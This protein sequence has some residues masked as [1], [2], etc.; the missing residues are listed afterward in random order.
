MRN[1]GIGAA[2]AVL[3]TFLFVKQQ[4]ADPEKHDRFVHDLQ[5]LKQLDAEINRDLLNSRY[6]LLSSYD[7]FVRKLD[8]MR[9]VGSNLHSIPSFIGGQQRDQIE[10]LVKRQDELVDEKTRLV[11]IFKSKNAILKNSL[12]YFPVLIEEASHAAA[13]AKDR[14]L[15]DHLASLLR[16]ILL[17]DL[18]PHSD[19]AAS[20]EPE[21]DLLLKNAARRA[22]S[23]A[24]LSSAAAH[25]STIAS[26]KS[27]VEAVTEALNSLP[28]ARSIDAISSA[29]IRDYE[30]AHKVQQIYRF[31]LYLCSVT[32]LGYGLDRT[33][34]LLKSQVE[35]EQARAANEAKSQFLANMSHEIRT[36][37]N[38]IIGMTELALDTE[39]T[40]EQRECLGMVKSSADSL[41]LLI[42]DI[43][44]FSKIEAGKLTLETIEFS[45]RDIL[46]SAVKAVSVRA[47][48][49]S[50]ELMY[51]IVPDV[52]DNLRGDP[53]RLRQIVLNLI[54][55]AVKFTSRGEV[56]LRVE[57]EEATE[58]AVTLHFIVSDTGVGIPLEK[59]QFIF[60]GFT[61]ADNSTT[62][63]FGGTGLGLTIS[64]RLVEAMGGRIW[65][66]SK[67]GLGSTFHFNARFALQANPSCIG[68]AGL[69]GLA[70]IAVLVVD[71]NASSRRFL[72]EIL[73]D[74]G[75]KPT[76]VD[77]GHEL[78][79]QLEKGK[80][81]GSP[82]PLVLIDA[83]MPEEDGFGLA[84][85]IKKDFRFQE[86]EVVMLTS[87]GLRG[88]A[89]KCRELGIRGHLTKPVRRSDLLDAIK[90]VLGWPGREQETLPLAPTRLFPDETTFTILLAEDNHVNQILATRILEK[91]GHTVVLAETGQAVLDAVEKQT[92][93]V[94][95]MDIHMPG[96]DG[97]EA[98]IAIRQRERM[99]GQHLPI[100]AMTA[101][102]MVG[103]EERCLQSGMDGYVTKPISA[104]DL[105]TAIQASVP[106][107]MAGV[108]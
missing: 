6:E 76:L 106:G 99:S 62:R 79:A 23:N 31:F 52:P 92:F 11:E 7:P 69:D 87:I 13:K 89:T 43:L 71:D 5:L 41:L 57:K 40:P 83:Q 14:K 82:F 10:K 107:H 46:D 38:G 103:D 28:T 101:S 61:Q 27:Q 42:N 77:R 86:S 37:M 93:D 64:T 75:M 88:D 98:T 58:K 9:S 55:N 73:Q 16:D 8:E 96:M 33:V 94:V 66:E 2:A 53:G 17:Y 3:L 12:R 25:A 48:Q 72:Q 102:A 84:E 97:L 24:T 29:Y 95:L 39:T 63:E 4:P 30:Q 100:I 18:T 54:G 1:I 45:L 59:Q 90:L 50:L 70:G 85:Q 20:L 108:G 67:P 19:L 78:L 80:A 60:E 74:W 26:F 49:K 81:L 47:H 21:I 44:D 91:R 15:Q 36:P 32:L 68:E 65:L 35:V 104:K 56:V 105:L 22:R 34:G 51:D